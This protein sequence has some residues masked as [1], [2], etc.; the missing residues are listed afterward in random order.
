MLN[1]FKFCFYIFCVF[2]SRYVYVLRNKDIVIRNKRN[3]VL[4]EYKIVYIIIF[5]CILIV[6]FR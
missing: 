2:F 3:K 6:F 5:E 1:W 4:K